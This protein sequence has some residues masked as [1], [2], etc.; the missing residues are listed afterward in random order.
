MKAALENPPPRLSALMATISQSRSAPTPASLTNSR[1][2]T[3]TMIAPASRGRWMPYFTTRMPPMK[4]PAMVMTG[5]NAEYGPIRRQGA[6][7]KAG[8]R[9]GFSRPG[10]PV[11]L[12]G[13]RDHGAVHGELRDRRLRICQ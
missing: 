12:Q 1:L 3:A 6:S 4:D 11:G 13:D 8:G 7:S 9:G 2:V 5:D 10:R